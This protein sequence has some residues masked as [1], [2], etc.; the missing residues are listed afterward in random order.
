MSRRI[1]R[2]LLLALSLCLAAEQVNGKN[3]ILQSVLENIKEQ[4]NK[5][6]GE[7]SPVI[8]DQFLSPDEA[9]YLLERYEFLMRDSLSVGYVKQE[10]SSAGKYRTSRS[11]RLPP[12]GDSTLFDVERRAAALAGF[13]HSYCEDIQMACYEEGELHGLHRD[14]ANAKRNADRSA[15]VLIYLEA[16]EAGGE[17][18]FTRRALELERDPKNGGPLRSEQAAL[19]LFGSYCENPKKKFV[20]VQP[21]V[22]LAVTWRNWLGDDLTTFAKGSTHGACPVAKGKKCV[23]QQW[24]SRT[25]KLPLRDE[26]LAAIFTVGADVNYRKDPSAD[27]YLLD[28][29]AN[30][31]RVVKQLYLLGGEAVQLDGKEGPYRGVGAI[32]ISRGL[33]ADL[34]PSLVD[35]SGFTISFWARDLKVGSTIVS[36]G[37]VSLV[38]RESGDIKQMFELRAGGDLSEEI[39]VY[40]ARSSDKWFWFS[41]TLERGRG[42]GVAIYSRGQLDGSVSLDFKTCQEGLSYSNELRILPLNQKDE[43]MEDQTSD[44]CFI[45]IHNAIL[46]DSQQVIALGQQAQR[47]DKNS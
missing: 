3:K 5:I 33:G 39:K 47:Y 20:V 9:R 27:F 13:N 21:K 19:Q 32:R 8:V 45:T 15:T 36:I 43:M 42:A 34:P 37:G 6:G 23:I 40:S 41:I 11:V 16:P 1:Y 12:L 30:E 28:A 14:D 46:N 22:G 10:G 7:P 26:Q 35:G 44:L 31:G 38:Y 4:I 25:T 29:S 17:T 2:L 18:L 24:I